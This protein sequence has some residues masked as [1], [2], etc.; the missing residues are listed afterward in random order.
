[1]LHRVD[2]GVFTRIIGGDWRLLP[3]SDGENLA[4]YGVT[5]FAEQ[6]VGQTQSDHSRDDRGKPPRKAKEQKHHQRHG[7][8]EQPQGRVGNPGWNGFHISQCK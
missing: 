5:A 3:A 4:C 7:N 6:K 2:D 8:H 1:M